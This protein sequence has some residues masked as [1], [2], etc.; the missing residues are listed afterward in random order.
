MDFRKLDGGLS[1]ALEDDGARAGEPLDVWVELDRGPNPSE[2]AA[3]RSLGI[4]VDPGE[5]IV[6]ARIPPDLVSSVSDLP[7]V[8][9]LT[10]AQELKMLHRSR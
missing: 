5:R 3:L 9:R 2:I 10:L 4:A 1:I 7:V 8:R 6:S